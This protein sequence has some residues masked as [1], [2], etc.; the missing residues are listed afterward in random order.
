MSTREDREWDAWIDDHTP[1]LR[2]RNNLTNCPCTV[3]E[4]ADYEE[5]HR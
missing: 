4:I 2:C 3:A 1:C 5:N